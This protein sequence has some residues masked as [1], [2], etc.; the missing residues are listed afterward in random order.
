MLSTNGSLQSHFRYRALKKC[1]GDVSKQNY[2]C[3]Q[4][5]TSTR[6]DILN[7]M[8]LVTM[9]KVVATVCE[10]QPDQE[11]TDSQREKKIILNYLLLSSSGEHEDGPVRNIPKKR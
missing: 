11:Y 9:E 1:L 2:S 3:V 10:R 7:G 5:N 8:N 4:R 6:D